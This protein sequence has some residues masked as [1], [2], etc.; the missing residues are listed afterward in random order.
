M[1]WVV[2]LG[3]MSSVESVHAPPPVPGE[4]PARSDSIVLEV[5]GLVPAACDGRLRAHSK[6]SCPVRMPLAGPGLR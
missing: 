2:V 3:N 4:A 5:E 1:L 6:N